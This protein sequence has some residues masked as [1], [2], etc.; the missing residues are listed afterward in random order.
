MRSGGLR[1]SL[2]PVL[3]LLLGAAWS[4]AT[5]TAQAANQP[6]GPGSSGGIG[7]SKTI[8]DGFGTGTQ[9]ANTF[10]YAFGSA[11]GGEGQFHAPAALAVTGSLSARTVQVYLAD[12]GNDRI[13]VLN[14]HGG[15]LRSFGAA[16]SLHRQFNAPQGIAVDGAGNI[17][18]ADT[19]N[20]RI[21]VFNSVGMFRFEIGSTQQGSG[22]GEFNAPQGI[23]VDSA[24][25]IFVA[26]TGNNRIQVF[27][28]Q[29]RFL[30][31]FGSAGSSVRQ[32]QAPTALAVTGSSDDSTELLY[33]ADT[34]NDRIQVLNGNNLPFNVSFMQSFGSAGSNAIQFTNPQG[35]ALD[36]AND[37]Y[38]ADAGN[39]R[40]AVYDPVSEHIEF[41]LGAPGSAP[42]QFNTPLGVAFDSDGNLFAADTNN[43]RIE[44]YARP[45]YLGYLNGA[46]VI[47]EGSLTSKTVYDTY[48]ERFQMGIIDGALRLSSQKDKAGSLFLSDPQIIVRFH[49]HFFFQAV[50]SDAVGF[51]FCLQ[52]NSPQ[53]LGDPGSALGYLE[54]AAGTSQTSAIP[55]SVAIAFDV[56]HNSIGLWSRSQGAVQQTTF[57]LQNTGINLNS[58]HAFAL[59][60][61]YFQ[62][63]HARLN[64]L[65]SPLQIEVDDLE[66][67]TVQTL[68]THLNIPDILGSEFAFVGF[69]GSHATIGEGVSLLERFGWTFEGTFLD[70]GIFPGY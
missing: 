11:G 23:A 34:G 54:T 27:D 61:R 66:T 53:A 67:K 50:N 10:S 33:V 40:I 21:Q 7:S 30:L 59:S 15:F 2:I 52:N 18:V 47:T 28:S 49:T 70:T 20:N 39:N 58:G 56:Q 24:G 14:G 6:G 68:E 36:S 26:D 8:H 13:Q 35:V 3:A 32:F 1:R 57:S 37:L 22:N 17:Y 60:I 69:T 25:R 62:T 5:Q 29:G 48:T 55:N 45:S 4:L 51:T 19:G 64:N 63:Q 16:G 9:S 41:T 44:V 12:T 42:G 38:V 65:A 43:N 31:S 46:A